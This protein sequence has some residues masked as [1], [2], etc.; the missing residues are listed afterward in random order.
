VVSES[1]AAPVARNRSRATALQTTPGIPEHKEPAV[2]LVTAGVELD[3]L[4]LRD[5]IEALGG[6]LQI[7]SHVGS[8]TSLLIE[9]PAAR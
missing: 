4:G 5:R 2:A 1:V 6:R 8:G 3:V 9:V 7:T